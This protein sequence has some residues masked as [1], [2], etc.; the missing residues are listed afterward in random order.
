M[1]NSAQ[2]ALCL[3]RVTGELLVRRQAELEKQAAE[4]R[5]VLAV[6]PAAVQSMIDN[7]KILGHQKEAVAKG[8]ESHEQCVTLLRDMAAH[9]SPSELQS[10]GTPMAGGHTKK[11]SVNPVGS[12]VDFS[13][14]DNSNYADILM[15]G[16]R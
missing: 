16:K 15:H 10:I 6:I 13:E 12:R 2:K 7:A 9:R 5:A 14:D 11:A 1:P 3:A 8:L 4:K